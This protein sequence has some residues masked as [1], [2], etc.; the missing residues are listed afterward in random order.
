M[1]TIF[2]HGE[3]QPRHAYSNVYRG[4]D[5]KVIYGFPFTCRHAAKLHAGNDVL[6]RIV[7]KP[8][9]P[10]QSPHPARP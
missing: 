8:K 2:S 5:G 6:Y 9:R 1:R 4:W 10:A 7:V 3:A